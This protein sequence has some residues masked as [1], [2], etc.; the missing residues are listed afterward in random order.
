MFTS[1]RSWTSFRT[2]ASDSSETNVI[3]RPLVPKRPAR[4]TCQSHPHQHSTFH[5]AS[6]STYNVFLILFYVRFYHRMC[7][8]FSVSTVTCMCVTCY[9]KYQS[10]NQSPQIRAA[11][12]MPSVLWHCW[13][14]IRRGADVVV[15]SETQMTCIYTVPKKRH[16]CSI[17]YHPCTSTD[18]G[19]FWQRC[20]WVSMLSNSV[21]KMWRSDDRRISVIDWRGGGR[22]PSLPA[23]RSWRR[24]WHAQ[25]P[26]HDR[27]DWW[28]PECASG[29]LWTAG[30]GWGCEQTRE[31]KYINSHPSIS[32]DSQSNHT[33]SISCLV[34]WLESNV[35]FQHKYGYI[36]DE[37]SGVE[38]YPLTQWRKASDIL[39]ST[40]AAFL[41]SSH[42]KGRGIERL[43]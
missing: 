23:C 28:P 1:N 5:V 38:S 13:M 4:A 26:C 17:L 34:G 3:A 11:I 22:C 24:C 32:T 2:R 37:T 16:W 35:S 33:R 20:C 41:F 10:I 15:C 12:Y 27:T 9:I 21:S 18:Y 43:I 7:I 42:Q 25:C 30:S 14:D 6:L 36:R 40:L 8:H 29:N 39:T 31:T 19:N